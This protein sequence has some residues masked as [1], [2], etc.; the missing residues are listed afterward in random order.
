MTAMRERSRHVRKN[1]W[2]AATACVLGC[3]ILLGAPAAFAFFPT[4]MFVGGDQYTAPHLIYATWSLR[5]MDVNANGNVDANEGVPI[6]F[7]SSV[8]TGLDAEERDLFRAGM[9]VWEQVP[10][11]YIAFRYPFT[12]DQQMETDIGSVDAYNFVSFKASAVPSGVATIALITFV[13]QNTYLNGVPVTGPAIVDADIA[14]NPDAVGTTDTIDV[15]SVV[16]GTAR[17]P[18]RA[19]ATHVTGLFLGLSYSPLENYNDVSIPGLT[20]T[21]PIDPLVFNTGAGLVGVTPTMNPGA[22]FYDLSG[23]AYTLGHIDLAPDDIA[24]VSFL[25]P[26]G[27][28]ENFFNL[29]QEARTDAAVGFPSEPISLGYI[30]VWCDTDNNP[31][32]PR[33]PIYDTL[34]SLYE[35]TNFRSGYFTLPKMFKQILALPPNDVL[36]SATYTVTLSEIETTPPTLPTGGTTGGGT[37]GGGTTGGGTTGGGEEEKAAEDYDSTHRGLLNGG[38]GF[39][40]TTGFPWQTFVEGGNNIY[41]VAPDSGTP[42]Y[43]DPVRRQIVSANTGKT[44]AQMLPGTKPMFGKAIN[45]TVCPLN[46]AASTLPVSEGPRA[47]RKFRDTVLLRTALGTA[48]A[49]AYY[50]AGPAVC[51]ILK[52]HPSA[53]GGARMFLMLLEWVLT[54]LWVCAIVAGSLVGMVSAW[55]LIRRRAALKTATLLVVFALFL[56]GNAEAQFLKMNTSDMVEKSD[57]ILVGKVVAVESR[58]TEQNQ[59]VTDVTIQVEDS[60]KGRLNKSGLVH[61]SQLGGEKDGIITYV[62]QYPA[63]NVGEEVVTFL[64]H[65]E[66]FGF[67]PL[68]GT[69]GKFNVKTEAATGKKYLEAPSVPAKNN[70]DQIRADME[71]TKAKTAAKAEEASDVP[72]EDGTEDPA[73]RRVTLDDLK[74]HI[75]TVEQE[76]KRK[77]R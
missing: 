44:L 68:S 13:P 75:K 21:L 72:K 65:N 37:T 52:R 76:L 64:Q 48:L 6:I 67:M 43:F 24:G 39:T 25:Y 27:D 10:S 20:V 7:D 46:L 29:R 61:F 55:W 49:E 30:Q 19:V 59:I 28:Q 47:L 73:A 58:W 40:P 51:G 12:I 4:G 33:V 62:P 22:F 2:R 54:H 9:E 31:A 71:K 66:K 50:R 42:L 11:A 14:I 45:E 77:N 3:V 69:G 38:N 60:W 53:M 74:S 36:F 56:A 5:Q 70:L 16:A 57:E 8:E 17:L 32:T 34:T 23:G 1:G 18:L 35:V 63:W 15:A 26:R 41:T